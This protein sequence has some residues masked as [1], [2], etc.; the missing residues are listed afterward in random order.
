MLEPLFV[1]ALER[2]PDRMVEMYEKHFED[3]KDVCR[4]EGREDL[5]WSVEGGWEPL[6]TFLGK[7]IP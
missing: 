3:I 4:A 6:C 5:E 1:T 7:P 2:N